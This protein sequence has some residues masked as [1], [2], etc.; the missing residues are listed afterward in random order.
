[1][2]MLALL[3][4]AS[5]LQS[6]GGRLACSMCCASKDAGLYPGENS[7]MLACILNWLRSFAPE[8]R[9]TMSHISRLVHGYPHSSTDNHG[10][11]GL[12]LQE[13]VNVHSLRE[14]PLSSMS[15]AEFTVLRA[16]C[17]MHTGG[18]CRLT[19]SGNPDL[20]AHRH[21]R[22]LN[23]W[24]RGATVTVYRPFKGYFI[25]NATKPSLARRYMSAVATGRQ[26]RPQICCWNH[27]VCCFLSP[28]PH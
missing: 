11:S 26:L 22:H 14:Q 2:H 21:R 19:L 27:R 9:T 7:W 4:T 18:Q 5:L 6:Y 23:T 17:L 3:S 13:T 1:M 20:A 8:K 24:H 12:P 28:Q 16:S 10:A 25:P 15:T